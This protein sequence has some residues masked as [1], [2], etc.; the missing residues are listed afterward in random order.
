MCIELN[1]HKRKKK[2]TIHKKYY[3]PEQSIVNFEKK[4]GT[5]LNKRQR[6][7]KNQMKRAK[8]ESESLTET[9]WENHYEAIVVFFLPF[10]R[11]LIALTLARNHNYI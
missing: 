10:H 2:W 9:L 6:E 5:Y 7:E 11:I 4:N 1:T 3:K 8:G